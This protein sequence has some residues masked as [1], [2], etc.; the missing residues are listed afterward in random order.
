MFCSVTGILVMFCSV[1]SILV[2]I[3]IV[4]YERIT[5]LSIRTTISVVAYTPRLAIDKS[6]L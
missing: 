2:S 5:K 6:E 3:N 1:T 4:Q